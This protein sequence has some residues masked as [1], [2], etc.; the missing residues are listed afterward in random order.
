M[1]VL[2]RCLL[3]IKPFF[4][5]TLLLTH[6]VAFGSSECQR[7]AVKWQTELNSEI[8]DRNAQLPVT[9]QSVSAERD[10]VRHSKSVV[11]AFTT[12][13]DVCHR[14]HLRIT[15]GDRINFGVYGSTAELN[16]LNS[17]V[18]SCELQPTEITI[19]DTT[20]SLPPLGAAGA[21]KL[22]KFLPYE[23]FSES[24]EFQ[25][26]D[27]SNRVVFSQTIRQYKR[28]RGTFQIGTVFTS[29]NNTTYSTADLGDG[30]IVVADQ[31]NSTG[32]FYVGSLVV[33]GLP[34]Y[35]VS[36][37]ERHSVYAGR[38]IVNENTWKDKLGLA[39]SFGLS[40]TMD[41]FGLGLSYELV[42]GINVTSS[43]FYRQTN[44]LSGLSIG[45]AFTGSV[46]PTKRIW[47]NEFVLGLSI[48][49]RYLT[50][51]FGSR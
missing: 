45:D 11:I 41:T 13:G 5:L 25:V 27:Q 17:K 36:R 1:D 7:A 33:Y 39:L 20:E 23:C 30:A 26:T 14:S 29:L 49:G 10:T 4:V 18:I 50:K 38:D 47:K 51:F 22:K 35:F 31:D 16:Q 2:A 8:S 44:E 28:Y 42:T 43:L 19:L 3:L 48:D 32:P 21:S 24:I 46:V 40:D 6:G 9:S 15:Q 37:S 12:S 34:N